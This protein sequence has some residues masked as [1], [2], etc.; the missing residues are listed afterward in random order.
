[1]KGGMMFETRM[2]AEALL[3]DKYSRPVYYDFR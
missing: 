2:T 3:L 1:M